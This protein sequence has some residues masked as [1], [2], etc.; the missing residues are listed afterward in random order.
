MTQY[1]ALGRAFFAA[2][3]ALQ[4]L[5]ASSLSALTPRAR[6]VAILVTGTRF[7]AAYENYAHELIARDAGLSEAQVR[8]IRAGETPV[9]LGRA[10]EVAWRI[11]GKLVHEKGELGREAWE[12][13]REVLGEEGMVALVGYV[14][15]YCWVSVVLNGFG[16][17]VPE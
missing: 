1:P 11:A 17:R 5:A 6:E 4:S 10:E 16:A 12:E 3:A 13:G 2:P 9:G 14:G 15:M 8:A 7:E